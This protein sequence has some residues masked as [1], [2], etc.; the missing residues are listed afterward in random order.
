MKQLAVRSL[1][2]G[3]GIVAAFQLPMLASYQAPGASSAAHSPTG[4]SEPVSSQTILAQPVQPGQLIAVAL[5]TRDLRPGDRGADVR[6]LQRY[7]SRNGLYTGQIDGA[8]G[9][10]T[11]DAVATY[12]RIRNLPATGLAD[13][14]TLIDMDFD[15][16]PAA[17]GTAAPVARSSRAVPIS[18]GALRLGSRGESVVELQ[19]RLNDYGIP[20]RVDG[21]Y[22]FETQQAVRTYQRVQGL[23]V[24]G[25]AD[26]D[27]LRSMG[28]SANRRNS[29]PYVAAVIADESR[30]AEVQQFFPEAYV[31]RVRRGR[32]INIGNFG[33]RFP[34]EARV[35][36]A[37]ARGFNTRVLYR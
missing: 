33:D 21:D 13:E 30:L 26:S 36:A 18:S 1:G 24:T 6:V 2:W 35:D 29:L 17:R 8:Y 12:Q 11:V 10:E 7:L 28:F 34:A 20:L 32:F 9:D 22:G 31:D 19:R 25:T 27:T 3:V 4:F 37:K 16:L 5:S 23:P 15:F 14:E